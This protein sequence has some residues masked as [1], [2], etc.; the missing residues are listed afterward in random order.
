MELLRAPCL[1]TAPSRS[2]CFD[3]PGAGSGV[4]PSYDGCQPDIDSLSEVGGLL[5][6]ALE[7]GQLRVPPGLAV[8]NQGAT[9]EPPPVWQCC[10]SE[11]MGFRGL[12]GSL[13]ACVSTALVGASDRSVSIGPGGWSRFN[14]QSQGVLGGLFSTWARILLTVSGG[15]REL[16][17][18]CEVSSVLEAVPALE[19][20]PALAEVEDARRH[21]GD[22][23]HHHQGAGAR[24]SC[25]GRLGWPV[26]GNCRRAP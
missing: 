23:G 22:A 17:L 18:Y 11:P 5:A 6:I 7:G 16:A 19:I 8:L 1:N 24:P 9:Q 3:V 26:V 12:S 4:R 25:D 13:G 15:P 21:L 20:G 2:P 10:S 14:H